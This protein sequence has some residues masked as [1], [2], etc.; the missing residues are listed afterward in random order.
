LFLNYL[1]DLKG[2]SAFWSKIQSLK[3]KKVLNLM[4][5]NCLAYHNGG[6]VWSAGLQ[7]DY[8]VAGKS[9]QPSDER[10]TPSRRGFR[11]RGSWLGTAI[12]PNS[13]N[14]EAPTSATETAGLRTSNNN[15][16]INI[17][18][19]NGNYCP[20]SNK[21]NCSSYRYRNYSTNYSDY[22]YRHSEKASS[23]P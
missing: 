13:P 23:A 17:A 4:L 5:T 15:H 3:C 7:M 19:H 12:A 1:E 10:H 18:A 21:S 22:N 20:S 14:P 16:H 9:P 2:V 11:A 6:W 8:S